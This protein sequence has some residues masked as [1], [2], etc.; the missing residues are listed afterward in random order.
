MTDSATP[1]SEPLA[2]VAASKVPPG[3]RGLPLLGSGH[4]MIFDPLEF[5]LEVSREHG[6]IV[7]FRLPG[8]R[9]YLLNRPSAIDDALRNEA[10]H[11]MKDAFTRQLSVVLGN[12]LLTSEGTFWRRQRRLAQ[13]AFHHQ[14]VRQYADAMVRQAERTV[15]SFELGEVR[16]IHKDM[17][18]LTLDVVAETLFG[19]DVRLVSEQIGTAVDAFTKRFSGF[20]VFLPLSIPTPGNRRFRRSLRQLDEI[21]YAII[22]E[23][24]ERHQETSDLLSMLLAAATE[25]GGGMS[26]KQLRDE[27]MTLLLAGHETTALVLS[28]ASYL[29]A[30]HPRVEEELVAEIARV[31]GDRPATAADL[32]SLTYA[33]AVIRE[34]MRLYPPAWAIGRE[35]RSR[36]RIG[37]YDVEP[38]TQLWIAQWVLHRDPQYFPNPERFE[39]ERWTDDFVKQLPRSA[40]LPFGGGP[41]V[42]IGNAFAMMEAVLLLV[43]IA[44]KVR[45]RLVSDRPLRLLPAVTL[46]PKDGI[47][48]RVEARSPRSEEAH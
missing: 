31:L 17:M 33:E 20:R 4:R 41:R 25:E 21:V 43:T 16:D 27:V 14:R 39:P 24:R 34:S 48:V 30:L 45:L 38:G 1:G 13:P 15:A 37:G 3:P 28:F 19:T 35:A 36:C 18:R 44:R 12:G 23:R 42:C 11:L 32:P 6:D 10:E 29:L 46:R 8:Q 7:H 2:E 22:R 40:Y 26:D 9:I 5:L 47:V